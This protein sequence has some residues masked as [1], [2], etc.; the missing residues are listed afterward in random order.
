MRKDQAKAAEEEKEHQR[1][2]SLAVIYH[3]F[4]QHLHFSTKKTTLQD[5]EARINFLRKKKS[6]TTTTTSITE[7]SEIAEV[8]EISERL[9]SG[10]H[11]NFFADL[12]G[13][14]TAV[15]KANPEYVK[16]KKDEQEKYEKQIG[17]L[18]YLGQDTNEALGKHDW[19]DSAPKRED[20]YNDKGGKVEVALKNKMFNDPLNVM[21]KYLSIGSKKP[22]DIQIQGTSISSST[23]VLQ[24][25]RPKKE[26]RIRTDSQKRHKHKKSKKSGRKSKKRSKDK[27]NSFN[28]DEEFIEKREKL[29]KLRSERLKREQ[30]EKTRTDLLLAKINGPI[31]SS[32]PLAS[33]P[34]ATAVP[35]PVKQKYNSQFNPGIAKQNFEDYR[36]Q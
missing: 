24:P 11:I 19:Y 23:A 34:M 29:L 22:K 8:D 4:C 33:K 6:S 26:E 7:S 1:K 10:E 14:K 32:K 20:A 12:E 13:G 18:T 16:E 31:E 36:R 3:L 30:I 35:I 15:T 25:E 2:I 28:K 9:H 21:N 17:Y 5:Q 27:P